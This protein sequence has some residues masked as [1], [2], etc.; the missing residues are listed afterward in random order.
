MIY[1]MVHV[2]VNCTD[3]ERSMAF[4][5]TI[6]FRVMHVF[7]DGVDRLDPDGDPSR[8]RNEPETGHTKGVVMTLGDHPRCFTKLELLEHVSPRTETAPQRAHHEVGISRIALRCK[9]IEGEVA[10]LRAAG[11]IFE[12]GIRETESVGT[13]RYAFFRDPDGVILEL[14]EL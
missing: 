13:A 3:L 11:V 10:R 7:G 9:D 14:I 6:G 5:R 12:T 1:D 8:G 2:N 4:Y